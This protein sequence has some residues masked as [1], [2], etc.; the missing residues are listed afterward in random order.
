MASTCCACA[1]GTW[2][3]A[4]GLGGARV[5]REGPPSLSAANAATE[6]LS[7]TLGTTSQPLSSDPASPQVLRPVFTGAMPGWT[8]AALDA[9]SNV[10]VALQTQGQRLIDRS[11]G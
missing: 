1:A 3:A 11:T 4:P 2:P 8:L 10:P 9:D 7:F 6:H 5:G